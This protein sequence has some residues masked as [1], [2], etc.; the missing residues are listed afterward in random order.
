LGEKINPV[1]G[2]AGRGEGK[3][4]RESMREIYKLRAQIELYVVL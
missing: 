2:C 1:V 3:R 4:K